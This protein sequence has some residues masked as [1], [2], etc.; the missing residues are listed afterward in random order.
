MIQ[1][2]WKSMITYILIILLGV[3][4]ALIVYFYQIF[5]KYDQFLPGVQIASVSV[6]GYDQEGAAHLL[7][8]ELNY[9]FDTPLSFHYQDYRY[10]TRLGEVI[11]PLDSNKIILGVW[12][13]EKKR[14]LIAKILNMD[15]SK[16]IEYPVKITYDENK[17]NS[18]GSA[19]KENLESDYVNAGLEID[20]VKGLVIL[21]SKKGVK[22]DVP[23]T[24][25][26]LPGEWVQLD[27]LLVEMV[28]NEETPPISENELKN[29]GEISTFTTWYNPKQVDRSHNVVLATGTL[30]GVVLKPG[31]V[32]SFNQTVGQLSYAKGYRDALII[33]GGKFVPGLGGGLCQVSTTLYNACLLAGLKIV[34]RHN[35]N[36]A[37]AYVSLGQDATVVHGSKDFRFQNTLDEPIYIWSNAGN[38]KVTMKIYGNLKYKQKI[39]VS[40]VVDQ[41]IDF[42]EIRETK[43]DLKPGTTKVEQTGGPGYVVRSFRTFY[44][45]DGSV[46][47][48]EQLAR[49][50]YRPLNRLV[51]VG[52][53]VKQP[54]PVQEVPALE[55]DPTTNPEQIEG[56]DTANNEVG[57]E[58]QKGQGDRSRVPPDSTLSE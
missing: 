46:A 14:S 11:K 58:G 2:K 37:V 49:D 38:G 20:P 27:K 35:H 32:F 47:R 5:Y 16:D 36:L 6:S 28:V 55:P 41:V 48:Q 1:V 21:P 7:D 40:H 30:N 4:A 24:L 51:Y 33:V 3:S 12:E 9:L 34:E 8:A 23:S 18:M 10:D 31:E 19:W 52:V 50:Q 43:N 25:A 45:N 54:D 57:I 17:L 53:P 13:Q 26:A 15:G 39:E 29:M 44:N 22:V 42:K 56:E